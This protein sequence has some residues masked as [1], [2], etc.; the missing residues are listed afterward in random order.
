MNGSENITQRTWRVVRYA[1]VVRFLGNVAWPVFSTTAQ[2]LKFLVVQATLYFGLLFTT[3][4]HSTWNVLILSFIFFWDLC[5]CN[6]PNL[7]SN[8]TFEALTRLKVFSTATL[9]KITKCMPWPSPNE[10]D[11]FA[12]L[13]KS[14]FS[15]WIGKCQ[16]KLFS[17][18]QIYILSFFLQQWRTL[19]SPSTTKNQPGTPSTKST[20]RPSCVKC[21]A[22]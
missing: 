5:T 3:V 10:N 17:S 11:A 8:K 20:E 6:W 22:V 16:L 18:N 14:N 19:A 15:S 12:R 4:C 13:V 21:K 1:R 2:V 7:R 9:M